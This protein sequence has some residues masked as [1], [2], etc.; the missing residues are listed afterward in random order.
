MR[1]T[2][3]YI[4]TGWP[5]ETSMYWE[6][7]WS[8]AHSCLVLLPRPEVRSEQQILGPF[9]VPGFVVV[10][11]ALIVYFLHQRLLMLAILSGASFGVLHGALLGPNACCSLSPV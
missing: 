7:A 9:T 3:S 8:I 11:S 10:R 1:F 4:Q 2:D 6:L 5:H